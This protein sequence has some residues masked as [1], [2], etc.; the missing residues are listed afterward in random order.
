MKKVVS[1]FLLVASVQAFGDTSRKQAWD[2][3]KRIAG[4]PPT[5]QVLNQMSSLIESKPG[6]EGLESAAAIAIENPN[7]YG[8]TLKAWAKTLTNTNDSNRVPLDDMSATIIGAI[9][10][11]D[12]PGKPFGR[13]LHEDVLYTGSGVAMYSPSN[14]DHYE[15]LEDNGANLKN[16]LVEQK[17]SDIGSVPDARGIAAILSSRAWAS[18]YYSMGTNRRAT[19]YLLKNFMC[20]EMDYIMDTNLP[21]IF[22]ARDVTR[23]PGGDSSEYKSYCVGC[24]AAQ[25]AMRPAWAY[26]DFDATTGQIS[27][28]QGQV[29]QKMNQAGDTFPDGWVTPDNN[30]RNLWGSMSVHMERLGFKPPFNGVGA[31]D[32][33]KQ[34]ARS[35]GFA[36]CMTYEAFKKVCYRNPS[37]S[38]SEFI[39]DV[40][41][42]FESTGNMKE[43]YK[44]VAAHCVEDKYEE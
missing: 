35:S 29:V 10:D 14:N 38:E 24:H 13:I 42:E 28:T 41:Q 9:R 31:A 15:Q 39:S 22:V 17:Q 20:S 6:M 25:D 27:Y 37:A 12:Q 33:G 30:F 44:K 1:L 23:S 3:H 7:F 16:V 43:V 32:L 18:A 8:V 19:F 26:Y 36:N 2:L 21:D 34:V 4:V 5:P 11:S 40:S